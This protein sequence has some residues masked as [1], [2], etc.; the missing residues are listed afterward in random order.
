VYVIDA[1]TLLRRIIRVRRRD[2]WTR[3]QLDAYRRDAL[4][5]LRAHAYAHSPFYRRLHRGLDDR[6]LEELP[7]V[8][9]AMLMEH[10]DELVTD[11]AVRLSAV[12][13]H[14]AGRHAEQLY[15]GRYRVTLTSGS[16]GRPGYFL[17]DENEW[18][19]I[20]SSFARGQEWAGIATNPVEQVRMAAVASASPWHLSSQIATTVRSWWRPTLRLAA[21]D[22]LPEIVARLNVWQPE[23]LI[24]YASMVPLLAG[25]QLAG[26]LQI[27]PRAVYTSSEVLTGAARQSAKAA[28]GDEPYDEYASTE[29][30]GIASEHTGCRRL[31]LYEDFVIAESVDADYRPVPPGELGARLLVTT[32]YS[33]T[34]PLIRYELSDSVALA[35]EP[36]DCGLPFGVLASVQ[37]RLQDW[38]VLPDDRG[39]RIAV[40]PLVFNRVMD[41]VPAAGW[42]IAQEADGSLTV[43]VAGA[44]DAGAATTLAAT[45]ARALVAHGAQPPPITVRPVDAIPKG[46]GGKTVLIKAY[47]PDQGSAERR[48]AA[49]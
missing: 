46:P 30:A 37:G 45:L 25:E 20:L 7:V 36:C 14:A 28:W 26:R 10:F 48:S 22:P 31:H 12:R 18:L 35:A 13:A 1:L 41:L 17:F 39:G 23:I 34:L 40:P 47:R 2:R 6:P 5:R 16:S 24:A 33:R 32:L 21:S 9:K 29:T 43:L 44:R 49:A 27:R 15:R 4:Q 38:L 19:H 8:T 11:R 3:R 42:Q